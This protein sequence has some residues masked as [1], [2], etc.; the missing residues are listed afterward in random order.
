MTGDAPRSADAD[1]A[2]RLRAGDTTAYEELYR[3][4]GT[5]LFNLAYRVLGHADEAQDQLQEIFLQVF[6]R[7]DSFKGDSSLSTWMYRL[8]MNLCL[9][10]LRSKAGKADRRTSGLDDAGP[11]KARP[12]ALE[13]TV[14]RLDLERAIAALPDACRAAFLLHDVEGF[15]HREVGKILGVSEGTSKSQVHKARLRIREHLLSVVRP[16]AATPTATR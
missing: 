9:D 5:R 2:A 16:R 6:R 11:V 12:G 13:H 1:L 7:I 15:E 8:A 4:H 3:Q 14:H 10:R